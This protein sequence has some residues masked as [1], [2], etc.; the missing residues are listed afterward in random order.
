MGE[1]FERISID[2]RHDAITVLSDTKPERRLFQE[3]NMAGLQLK[4]ATP[5]VLTAETALVLLR[6]AAAQQLAQER[7]QL[8]G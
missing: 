4:Q 5:R 3:W 1:T 2:A 6:T 8:H 7:Q